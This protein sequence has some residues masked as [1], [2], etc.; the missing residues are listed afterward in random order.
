MKLFV[1]TCRSVSGLRLRV[2]AVSV[3]TSRTLLVLGVR[4]ES[5]AR[6]GRRVPRLQRRTQQFPTPCERCG[7]G[8][9]SAACP[10][11][12]SRRRLPARANEWLTVTS[13]DGALAM[14]GFVLAETL[15]QQHRQTFDMGRSLQGARRQ[16]TDRGFSRSLALW[17]T[18]NL[19]RQG[20]GFGWRFDLDAWRVALAA[21]SAAASP[22]AAAALDLRGMVLRFATLHYAGRDFRLTDV[23]GKVVEELIA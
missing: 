13:L 22:E 21:P 15:P 6:A 10:H 1:V 4:C 12:H 19:K 11:Y 7:G 16:L 8:H 20:E 9:E 17:M 18:T 14:I 2:C 5:S 3:I 23:H